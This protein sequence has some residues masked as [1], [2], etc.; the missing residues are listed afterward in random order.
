MLLIWQLQWAALVLLLAA[1]GP[2]CHGQDDIEPDPFANTRYLIGG[3]G[4]DLVDL[5]TSLEPTYLVLAPSIVRPGTVY[6]V[7]VNILRARQPVDTRAALLRDG[8]QISS[9]AARLQAGY[10]HTLL[11]KVPT[12]SVEGNYQ[13]RVEGNYPDTVGGT[14]FLNET[15]VHFSTRFLTILIQ[16]SRPVYNGDQ[17]VCFRAI[18]LTHRL[19]PFD[20]P[21]DAYVLDPDGYVMRWWPSR[22]T[23]NGVVSLCFQLP[24]LPKTG[25][26]MIRIKVRGQVQEKQVAVEKYYVPRYEV[27]VDMP[28]H[29]LTTDKYVEGRVVARFAETKKPAVGNMTLDLYFREQLETS[30]NKSFSYA[31]QQI[32]KWVNGPYQFRFS[33]EDLVARVPR[34]DGAQLKVVARMHEFF[35]GLNETGYCVSHVI[36][37]TVS[38]RFVGSQP[39]VFKPGMPFEGVM[40]VSYHDLQPLS[41]ERL[42]GSSLTITSSAVGSGTR[43]QEVVPRYE[44]IDHRYWGS[45]INRNFYSTTTTTAR[46]GAATLAPEWLLDYHRNNTV[47]RLLEEQRFAEYRTRGLHRFRF[48]MPPRGGSRITLTAQYEDEEGGRATAT[49]DLLPY[50]SLEERYISVETSTERAGVGQY[51]VLHVRASFQMERFAYVVMSK[52]LLLYANQETMT[53]TGRTVHTLSL[54][55]SSEMAPTFKVLVYHVTEDGEVLSDAITLPVEGIGS[56]AVDLKLNQDK[57]HSKATVEAVCRSIPGSFFG[58]SGLRTDA[59]RAAGDSELSKASVLRE[60]YSFENFTRSVH[61]VTRRFRG[62][63]HP[64]DVDYFSAPNYGVDANR[65]FAFAQLVVFTDGAVPQL[66]TT[67]AS[68]CNITLGQR[69]CLTSGCYRVEE[70]CDGR[71]ACADGSDEHDC[72]PHGGDAEA[73]FRRTRKNRLRTMYDQRQGD[74]IWKD[75]QIG[76]RATEEVVLR[77][78]RQDALYYVTAFS[79]SQQNGFGIIEQPLVYNTTTPFYMRME[80]PTRCRRGEQIGVRAVLSNNVAQEQLA[81]L[82]LPA[83]DQ[84]KFV[85]VEPDG[86]VQHFRPRLSG[87][88]HQHLVVLPPFTSVE[89]DIPIAPQIQQ[90]ELT[91]TL[92][93]LTQVGREDVSRTMLVEPEGVTINKH[94]SFLLDLKNRAVEFKYL[95]VIVEQSPVVPYASWRRFVFDSPMG[96][97]TVTGDVVGPIFPT[98]GP[99]N[100]SVLLNRRLRSTEASAFDFGANLWSLHYLRLT[101]QFR[102]SAARPVF[103]QMNV[104][105]AAVL[106]RFDANGAYRMWDSAPPSVW[107]TA[108][109]TRLFQEAKFQ[110]WENFLYIEPAIVSKAM[111]WLVQHQDNATGAFFETSNYSAPLDPKIDPKSSRPSDPVPLRNISLTAQVL[112]TLCETIDSLQGDLR[113]RA[114]VAKRGAV[115]YLEYQLRTLSRPYEV[116]VTTYALMVANSVERNVAFNMLDRLKRKVDGM[117]YW[118]PAPIE[119]NRLTNEN[120][121]RNLLQPKLEQLYDTRAVETTAY[122][123]LAYLIRDGVNIDQEKMVLWLNTMRMN[124][125]GFITTTDS[126]VALRALVEYSYRARLRDIT[127]MKVNIEATASELDSTLTIN[128]ATLMKTHRLDFENVWGHLNVIGNGA[129]Q[130]VVQLDV[131]YG[132]DTQIGIKQPPV[133]SFNLTVTEDFKQFRNKSIGVVDVCARW[134]YLEEGPQSGSAVLEIENPT[135]YV[136][137]QPDGDAVVREAQRTGVSQLRDVIGGHTYDHERSTTWFFD[138]IPGNESLCFNYTIRRW[139]PVANMTKYRRALLYEQ[140]QPERFEMQMVNSTVLH[141][142]NICEVCGSY[143]CPYCPFY[144]SAGVLSASVT[145][146]ALAVGAVLWAGG[147]TG[148]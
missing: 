43:S 118:S 26:W 18:M 88:A 117:I 110:D 125:G 96:H 141:V 132:V 92:T 145:L 35:E 135:G 23:N 3:D 112:I 17:R 127:E 122:G 97:V 81:L 32:T 68:A 123:L 2:T 114:N 76:Y 65:T 140:Y 115:S 129:G 58:L 55:V 6:R 62:G 77:V 128:N 13:L 10:P 146:L 47:Q 89:V 131:N 142:L 80:M 59:R 104:D 16:T 83:S 111:S 21:V 90:G 95:D 84:Y 19:R 11:L 138:H 147:S 42:R 39:M 34:I 38:L 82:V 108:W 20:E 24:F 101:S 9:A 85:H 15:S 33:M 54:P 46:P 22:P 116:A 29:F 87:G 98:G 103:E 113:A 48:I 49:M 91:V 50:Y 37:S 64:D 102:L 109:V 144:S 99:V 134:V 71:R 72:A 136:L 45:T 70:R 126:L 44:A 31:N 107:L 4:G 121:Q 75:V 63:L 8:V 148:S 36:N 94:T 57:D 79:V 7:M 41:A 106:Y 86:Y 130:A 73:E 28:M 139:F 61:S 105:M 93:A 12:T 30:L 52:G 133:K 74:W 124:D 78:P 69:S 137:Y 67:L 119:T 1:C 27:F 14:L 120:S 53:Q 60:L 25:M 66:P 5:R 56:G 143:Q 40:A 51:V 100:T